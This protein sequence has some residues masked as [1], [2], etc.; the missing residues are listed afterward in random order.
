MPVMMTRGERAKQFMAFD[1]MKGLKEEIAKREEKHFRVEKHSVSDAQIEK[2]SAVLL[3]LKK[4]DTVKIYCYFRFHDVVKTGLVTDVNYTFK[5]IKIDDEKIG[6][7]DIYD[8]C[9]C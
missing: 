4:H 1:A 3:S 6:F 7:D 2:N 9:V 8:I 5:F